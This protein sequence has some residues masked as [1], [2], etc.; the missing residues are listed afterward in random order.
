[1]STLPLVTIVVISYNQSK[2]INE[3][4]D[5]IKNQSY[6]NI[7]LIVADDAST[8]NSVEIFDS[9]LKDNN[10]SAKKN[11][12][13]KNT[14]LATVLNECVEL[15]TGKYIKLIAADD[16]LHPK[17][18]EKCVQKLEELGDEYGM[19]FT[20]TN[21]IDDNSEIINIDADYNIDSEIN[22]YVL[23]KELLK[24][25]IISAL[26]VVMSLDVLKVTGDYNSSLLVEDYYRW[27][28]INEN[29]LIAYIPD[30]LAFYRYH[31]NNI[32]KLK[33]DRIIKEDIYLK[34]LYDKDGDIKNIINGYFLDRYIN[35]KN[36]DRDIIEQYNNYSF[37]IKRLSIAIKY[38]IPLYAYKMIS[39]II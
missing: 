22:P 1:M 30:K 35:K 17:A 14:G 9:W 24:K 39:K 7:E 6:P 31:E 34:I 10:Y 36:I 2:Y 37:K 18:I 38:N 4:L 21:T 25:N 3:N 28:K 20:N 15:A 26:S 12:H 5:S 32:T 19:V 11:Y 8:D 29:Y 13:T 23:K 27:L 16:F 33:K